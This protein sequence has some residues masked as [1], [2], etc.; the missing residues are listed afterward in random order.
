FVMIIEAAVREAADRLAAA[1]L[2]DSRMEAE[3]LVAGLLGLP[4][5]RLILHRRESVGQA[6]SSRLEAGLRDRTARKP[7][8]YILGE[9]PFG[10]LR[11]SVTADVLIPR[12]ETEELAERV[13]DELRAMREPR[14]AVDVGTGSGNLALYMATHALVRR[15]IGLDDSA[16][17]LEV[18]RTN[19]RLLGD[20]RCEW[21][22]GDLL[23]PVMSAADSADLI[24][25]NLPYVR[26]SDFETL[27]PEL[28]WEPRHALDGGCD[29]LRYIR[30]LV[31]QAM[32]A[33]R[34]HGVLFLEIGHDQAQSVCALFDPRG[35]DSPL[36]F[37]DLGGLPRIVRAARKG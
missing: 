20:R 10:D 32:E 4:R 6:D 19:A 21:M 37:K 7:L 29:G 3:F 18:A 36:V 11:L 25:A 30:P 1:G 28:R 24:V 15:V 13:C 31:G 17:A 9:Q 34:P 8:A 14:L 22:G 23:G 26:T 2:R 5:A 27:A 33:L 12:P 16:A 35:W